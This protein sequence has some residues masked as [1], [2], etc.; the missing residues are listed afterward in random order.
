[1][2]SYL[3]FL[4]LASFASTANS[5]NLENI[6]L[7]KKI[8]ND[9][10]WSALLHIVDGKSAINDPDFILSHQNFSLKNELIESIRLLESIPKSRCKFP[11]RRQFLVDSLNLSN[12]ELKQPQCDD[13]FDFK[14][15]APANNISL[16]YATENISQPSS[17]MGHIMLKIDGINENG[18]PVEHGVSFFTE[19]NSF[20]VPLIIWE[21][22]ITGKN[23]FFQLAPFLPILEHYQHTE[24]RNVWEYK[25][26]FTKA[27]K[28]L[29]H[30]HLWELK[31]TSLRYYF[32][33][34]N[35]AT[36]TKMLLRVGNPHKVEINSRWL[37][38]IDIVKSSYKAN[39]LTSQTLTPS[40]KWQLQMLTDLIKPEIIN[41]IRSFVD[42]DTPLTLETKNEEEAYLSALLGKTYNQYQF[43]NGQY[44]KEKWVSKNVTIN[45][46]IPV[47]GQYSLDLSQYK[48]PLK[49]PNDSQ[50]SFG[51]SMLN[52]Q[53]WINLR[54]IPA[55]HDI[56][57]DNRQFFS[58]N[59]LKLM[60]FSLLS[61]K[62]SGDIKLENWTLYSAKSYIPWNS[63]TGGVSGHFSIGA[64]QHRDIHLTPLLAGAVYGGAGYTY[65]LTKDINVFAMLNIGLGGSN[66]DGYFYGETEVGFYLYE[67][68]DMK[69]F[70]NYKKIFNQKKTK[71]A[72]NV[73]EINQSIFTQGPWSLISEYE[74]RW[75]KLYEDTQYAI[76]LKY[77]F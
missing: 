19:L 62:E 34:Y 18:I 3:L 48:N 25:L 31:N 17:M 50:V 38:P 10:T 75:N 21:S 32:N 49:T 41:H 30:N 54:Y 45:K 5:S 43:L 29:F 77:Q 20:N 68:F 63:L 53:E 7:N 13:F 61:N 58:E 9:P 33:S 16:I 4:S 74:Y 26:N 12:D 73:V 2:A 59:E 23:G 36:F 51:Y 72:Q 44:N 47:S 64:E 42:K 55:S 28:T 22:L 27:E 37:S 69:T 76:H 39:L 56:E 35:C 52:E 14:N 8:H 1:M 71:Y 6:A 24:Q 67:I 40:N 70:F 11:A 65:S 46:H 66:S 15:K 57:D 60:S